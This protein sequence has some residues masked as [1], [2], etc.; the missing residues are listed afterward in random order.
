VKRQTL[1]PSVSLASDDP[2]TQLAKT[3][4]SFTLENAA[5]I[6]FYAGAWGQRDIDES[7][8]TRFLATLPLVTKDSYREHLMNEV[9]W[10]HSD[11]VSHTSGTT[12]E[13]VFRHRSRAEASAI[14]Q[15]FGDI[16]NRDQKL[17][18]MIDGGPHGML[19]PV[20]GNVT[21]I[22]TAINWH[23]QIWVLLDLLQ[24]RFRLRGE[25]RPVRVL[26]G[27]AQDVVVVA[28]ALLT[29]P[30]SEPLRLEE[31]ITTGFLDDAQIQ[32][33][34][35]AFGVDVTRRYS[36]SEIFGGATSLGDSAYQLDP[37]V[38]GEVLSP[39]GEGVQPGEVGELVLTEL[40]PF[41]QLQPLIRYCTGDIVRLVTAEPL[42]F[43]W[44][45]RKLQ[46]LVPSAKTAI[47]YADIANILAYEPLVARA[48]HR[49][50]LAGLEHV[51]LG[52]ADFSVDAS[53]ANDIRLNIRL[54]RNPFLYYQETNSMI[55]RLWNAMGML[56]GQ[57][58]TIVTLAFDIGANRKM[59]SMQSPIQEEPPVI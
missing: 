1:G 36:L 2:A 41:I 47:G 42:R 44:L 25:M 7:D 14:S 34:K 56:I 39:T 46:C 16:R 23:S 27:A 45:G 21:Y 3:L 43:K 59:I 8:P 18:L 48:H 11:Y 24:T 29:R 19:L 33:L 12:G 37:V 57:S 26:A 4:L 13:M 58:G 31:V 40:F 35:R 10:G 54:T 28:Q 15:L 6:P 20:P 52:V 53:G 17:G 50:P 51:E 5:K 30:A 49:S 38:V 9:D 22:P 55:R 32:L